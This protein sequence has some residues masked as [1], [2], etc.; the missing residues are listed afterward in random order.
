MSAEIESIIISTTVLVSPKNFWSSMYSSKSASR[1]TDVV[2]AAGCEAE[3]VV[4]ASS[5]LSLAVVEVVVVVVVV[6]EVVV[7]VVAVSVAVVVVLAWP[8]FVLT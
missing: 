4:V 2:D 8:Y 7:V 3:V 1:V 6:V 5:S